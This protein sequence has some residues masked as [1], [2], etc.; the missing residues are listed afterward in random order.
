MPL[1]AGDRG[2]G[3]GLVVVWMV[4]EVI[5]RLPG[6]SSRHCLPKKGLLPT[7]ESP[8]TKDRGGPAR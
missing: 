4:L 6:A 2:H 3:E 5:V 7:A 8:C 1:E